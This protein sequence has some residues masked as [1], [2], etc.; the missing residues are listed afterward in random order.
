M[1]LAATLAL[2]AGP[3]A[4][5]PVPAGAGITPLDPVTIWDS[6]ACRSVLAALGDWCDTELPRHPPMV[7]KDWSEDFRLWGGW[8]EVFSRRFRPRRGRGPA[9]DAA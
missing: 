2:L 4:A 9:G 7:L 6:A 3:L 5:E 1:R 8:I